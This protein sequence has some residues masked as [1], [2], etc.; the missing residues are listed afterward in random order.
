[1][2]S[3][4]YSLPFFSRPS[5]LVALALG[6]I[7]LVPFVSEANHSCKKVTVQILK[8]Y[9]SL[10]HDCKGSH[11]YGVK[12]KHGNDYYYA[13]LLSPLNSLKGKQYRELV[14][15]LC[16]DA[17]TWDYVTVGTEGAKIFDIQKI[18]SASWEPAGGLFRIFANTEP[19]SPFYYRD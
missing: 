14:V 15:V 3:S 11:T 2:K 16:K 9:G 19:E 17:V 18:S 5:F 12:V 13:R 8:Y 10:G 4:S 6:F 1:M 7:A